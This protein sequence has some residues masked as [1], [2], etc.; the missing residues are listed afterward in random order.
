MCIHNGGLLFAARERRP[1]QQQTEV[2]SW[3]TDS[4][5]NIQNCGFARISFL[6]CSI[7]RA[8]AQ[9][10]PRPLARSLMIK[11]R[12]MNVTED[13]SAFMDRKVPLK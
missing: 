13:T 8:I 10:L 2:Q 5:K 4:S 7:G 12:W 9:S 3:E 11:P 6:A 1:V